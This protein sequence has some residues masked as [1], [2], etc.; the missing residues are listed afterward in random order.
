MPHLMFCSATTDFHMGSPYWNPQWRATANTCAGGGFGTWMG[1]AGFVL[2]CSCTWGNE[3]FF[4]RAARSSQHISRA[5]I[6]G[7]GTVSQRTR[8][9]PGAVRH[10]LHIWNHLERLN[11]SIKT[12]KDG[13]CHWKRF[14]I[15][16]EMA[17]W[18]KCLLGK[19][20]DLGPALQ[21]LCRGHSPG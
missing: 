2:A 9:P 21:H 15:A 16:R 12:P 8:R 7:Y 5:Q 11:I 10:R 13:I 17:W 14:H 18:R 20:K 3:R 19:H 4:R 6:C 1:E